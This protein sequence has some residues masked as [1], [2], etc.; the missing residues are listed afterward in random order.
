M[1]HLK[2]KVLIFH[3]YLGLNKIH[4]IQNKYK[5]LVQYQNN[6]KNKVIVFLVH[7]NNH[8]QIQ[9]NK[10][11]KKLKMIEVNHNMIQ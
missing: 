3:K 1:I 8:F 7:G 5:I 11:K 4:R 6:Q 2:Y 10:L 9:F